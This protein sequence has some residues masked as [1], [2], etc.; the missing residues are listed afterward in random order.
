[1]YATT[2]AIQFTRKEVHITISITRCKVIDLYILKVIQNDITLEQ[3][4]RRWICLNCNY[5]SDFF[6]RWYSKSAYVG[7]DKQHLRR[8]PAP[9][10]KAVEK[11]R[12]VPA[13]KTKSSTHHYVACGHEQEPILALGQYC[14]AVT[15]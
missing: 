10:E 6:G 15:T 14:D 12:I 3:L 11:F 7:T 1:L 5:S 13:A 4:E 9:C 2:A 8:W